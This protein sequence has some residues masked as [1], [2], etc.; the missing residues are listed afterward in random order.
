M[1]EMELGRQ[2]ALEDFEFLAMLAKVN[3]LQRYRD[4]FR[5]LE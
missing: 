1:T 2:I 3:W 4:R 5:R